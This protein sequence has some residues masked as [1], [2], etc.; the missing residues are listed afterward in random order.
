MKERGFAPVVAETKPAPAVQVW[1]RPISVAL[2]AVFVVLQVLAW[3]VGFVYLFL[4]DLEMAGLLLTGALVLF[5]VGSWAWRW[6]IAA[7]YIGGRPTAR[8]GGT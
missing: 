8:F 2:L 6:A 1:P 4:N 3:S 5:L 7:G